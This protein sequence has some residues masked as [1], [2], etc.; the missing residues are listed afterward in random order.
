MLH[1]LRWELF[2]SNF[3]FGNCRAAVTKKFQ[4]IYSFRLYLLIYFWEYLLTK[5]AFKIIIIYLV[6]FS[7]VDI[8]CSF[9]HEDTYPTVVT[10][11]LAFTSAQ[12]Q[13]VK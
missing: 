8:A 2:E 4:I 13:I 3:S 6:S 10:V 5:S 11:P 9:S 1:K 7:N 12:R